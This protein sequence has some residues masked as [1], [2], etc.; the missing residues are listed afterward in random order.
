VVGVV[1]VVVVAAGAAAEVAASPSASAAPAGNSAAVASPHA[2]NVKL[3]DITKQSKS[4][5]TTGTRA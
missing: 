3:L 1:A 5:W 2:T 4:T